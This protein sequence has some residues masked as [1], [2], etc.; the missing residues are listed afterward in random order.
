MSVAHILGGGLTGLVVANELKKKYEVILYEKE[1]ELGGLCRTDTISGIK[2]EGGPHVWYEKKP[3]H[4]EF[5]EKYLKINYNIPYDVKLSRL[6]GLSEDNLY[7]FPCSIK[8]LER[9]GVKRMPT[10]EPDYANVET[11]FKSQVGV[12]AYNAFFKNYNKKQWGIHPKDMGADWLAKRPLRLR[13]KI[14]RMF[15][16]LPAGY[17]TK[18]GYNPMLEALIKGCKVAYNA[19]VVDLSMSDD[20]V[21]GISFW[22]GDQENE[23]IA[24][25]RHG[26]VVVNTLPTDTYYTDKLPWRGIHKVFVLINGESPMPTYSTTFPNNYKFTR[27]VDYVKHS[28]GKSKKTLLSFAF[29]HGGKYDKKLNVTE[30]CLFLKGVTDKP[31]EIVKELEEECVYPVATK[32]SI[33]LLKT[34]LTKI[35][36]VN[37]LYTIGRLGLYCYVSMANAI[38]KALL[39]CKRLESRELE[40]PTLKLNFYNEVRSDL[41]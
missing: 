27:V 14:T 35:S 22:Q 33:S 29:P 34:Q 4:R 41:W 5:I 23:F 7:D 6:G 21:H 18:T 13:D 32:E 19:N 20:H 26:D 38:E 25:V 11:F 24:P 28:G 10:G 2:A 17:P 8:N 15:G 31:F 40:S 9:L 16:D 37:N 36:N 12:K 1:K 30:V 3:E 39:F